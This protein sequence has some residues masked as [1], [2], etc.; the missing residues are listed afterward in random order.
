[1]TIEPL[2]AQVWKTPT[3]NWKSSFPIH[4]WN[5]CNAPCRR[6]TR[7]TSGTTTAACPTGCW[8]PLEGAAPYLGSVGEIS[9]EPELKVEVTVRAE[10]VDETIAAVKRVHPYEEPVINAIPLWRTSF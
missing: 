5:H 1:M 7:G 2:E 4:I 9:R 10:H 6:S 3:A 8:R